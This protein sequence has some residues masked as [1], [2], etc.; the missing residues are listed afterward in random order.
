MV[1]SDEGCERSVERHVGGRGSDRKVRMNTQWLILTGVGTDT[2]G[3]GGEYRTTVAEPAPFGRP[4]LAPD[5]SMD[6]DEDED[7]FFDDD[8]YEDEDF[9]DEDEALEDDDAAVEEGEDLDEDE[10]DEDEEF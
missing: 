3:R 1:G 10:D 6:G 7:E 2:N 5:I 4:A 9:E 8:D